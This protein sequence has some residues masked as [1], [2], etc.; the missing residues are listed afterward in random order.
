LAVDETAFQ[1]RNEHVTVLTDLNSETIIEIL[2]DRKNA[3]L[4]E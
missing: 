3:T 4:K 1:K 2:G